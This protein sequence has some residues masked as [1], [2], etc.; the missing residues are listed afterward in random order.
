MKNIITINRQFGSGGREIG[1]RLADELGW[2]YYDKELI[3]KIAEET[4]LCED[5]IDKHDEKAMSTIYPFSFG[6]TFTAV[7]PVPENMIYITQTNIIKELAKKGNCVIIGR[8]A[9]HILEEEAF[10]ILIYSS[11]MDKRIDRCYDKVPEDKDKSRKE[12][13][14]KIRY[15]D[16]QRNKYHEFYCGEKRLD[17]NNYN[18]CIDTAELPIK[19]AVKLIASLYKAE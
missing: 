13:E 1:K 7:Y 16:K 12:M 19:A 18:L 3:A 5:F 14:S 6:K 2:S 11:N 9:S 15:I 4:G 17:I 10:K 8:C